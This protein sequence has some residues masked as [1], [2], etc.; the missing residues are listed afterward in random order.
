ML[1]VK[2]VAKLFIGDLIESARRVQA[3]WI[4]AGTEPTQIDVDG[5]EVDENITSIAGDGSRTA[6]ELTSTR[7]GRAA[8]ARAIARIDDEKGML[9]Q[10]RGPL[11]PDHLREA[12][13]RHKEEAEGGS[14][15]LLGLWH[16]QQESG[17]ERFAVKA[18]GRRIFR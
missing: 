9:E 13:R 6:K 15:G 5:R 2:S 10:R 8:V 1:A 18:R 14:V 4:A 12:W 7:E 3:E 16:A 11:R 17:V